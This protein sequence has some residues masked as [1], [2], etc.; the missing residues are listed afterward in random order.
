MSK[1]V[2]LQTDPTTDGSIIVVP[3]TEATLNGL[4]IATQ[5]SK[6]VYKGTPTDQPLEFAS[7]VLINNKPLTFVGAKTSA[8][9]TILSANQTTATIEAAEQMVQMKNQKK[10]KEKYY[11]NLSILF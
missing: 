5:G 11:L 10:K 8:G 7:G 4:P 9:A 2:A 6:L 3:S 1:K